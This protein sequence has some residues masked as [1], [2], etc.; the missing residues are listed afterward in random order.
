MFIVT[1]MGTALAAAPVPE[2]SWLNDPDRGWAL[3]PTAELGTLAPLYHQLQFG[4]DGTDF[5]LVS[6]GGQDN[7]FFVTRW[8]LDLR[9][10]GN[11]TITLLYQPLTLVTQREADRNLAFNNV[12]FGPGTPVVYTYGFDFYRGSITWDLLPAD[13]AEWSLGA[14]LQI[15]NA[16]INIGSL[17]GE[18]L[19][20]NRD[21]G[22]VPII[23][24]RGRFEGETVWWGFEA[25]GFYAPIKYLNGGDSDVVGAILDSSVRVGLYADR[26]I[27]PFLNLRYLGGGAEGTESD[28]DPGRDGYVRNWLH[29]A[30]LTVGF[31]VR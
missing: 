30:T 18:Q 22:P 7:L 4:R 5:D 20:T 28:P 26:G 10:R 27:D 25:D 16:T 8:S 11:T 31:V 13:D 2:D 6:Q 23:K 19:T 9:L 24:T 21:I 12:A 3:Q 1:A 29:F 14:S 15:R 17:N